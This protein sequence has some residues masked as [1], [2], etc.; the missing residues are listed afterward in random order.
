MGTNAHTLFLSY[1]RT[2]SS[3]HFSLINC[4]YFMESLLGGVVP[5][6]R[7]RIFLDGELGIESNLYVHSPSYFFFGCDEYSPLT[8][9]YGFK[10]NELIL[11]FQSNLFYLL[12]YY[13]LA[14]KSMV[15]LKGMG[16]FFLVFFFFNLFR[17]Q[18]KCIYS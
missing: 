1:L 2:C 5:M 12:L 15:K 6:T 11:Y 7:T 4:Y 18:R 9:L 8:P 10:F 16:L 3:F 14:K 13:I 17:F